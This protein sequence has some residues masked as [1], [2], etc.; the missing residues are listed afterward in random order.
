[1]EIHNFEPVERAPFSSSLGYL[2]AGPSGVGKTTSLELFMRNFDNLSSNRL[3]D[4]T[5]V[6]LFMKEP[7]TAYDVILSLFPS[8]SD[9]LVASSF[10]SEWTEKEFWRTE[11]E[12]G[13][14]WSL[15][16][17]DDCMEDICQKNSPLVNFL[18]ALLSVGLHHW[19][20]SVILLIQAIPPP[21][22]TNQLIR[23]LIKQFHIFFV[24]NGLS[25]HALRWLSSFL[26]S[27]KGNLI[28]AALDMI[29][30]ARGAMVMIDNRFDVPFQHRILYGK[31]IFMANEIFVSIT[32]LL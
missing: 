8:S 18:Q 29:P 24:F 31:G 32:P 26:T 15:I 11:D 2:F 17:L 12:S 16:I 21:T 27:S 6:L 13:S 3:H 28:G 23:S 30:R 19:R 20:L 1:M 7:Q 10:S 25:A 5:K 4:C 14:S 22:S 9:K